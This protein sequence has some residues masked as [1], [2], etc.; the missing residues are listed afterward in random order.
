MFIVF[1]L[2]VTTST[3]KPNLS[4]GPPVSTGTNAAQPASARAKVPS[5][6]AS[7]FES[8]L[9]SLSLEEVHGLAV[10][11]TIFF[12]VRLDRQTPQEPWGFE[13]EK[14]DAR[15]WT[16]SKIAPGSAADRAVSPAAYFKS[17]INHEVLA[18]DSTT[19]KSAQETSTPLKLE[20]GDLILGLN[21]TVAYQAFPDEM[22]R[23]QNQQSLK[24]AIVRTVYWAKSDSVPNGVVDEKA[25]ACFA[26]ILSHLETR[27]L[28][29]GG[30]V[31]ALTSRVPE[32]SE[33]RASTNFILNQHDSGALE[34]FRIPDDSGDATKVR[35]RLGMEVVK[36]SVHFD[37]R[38]SL[39]VKTIDEGGIMYRFCNIRNG[40]YIDAINGTS[41]NLVEA[42]RQFS[43]TMKPGTQ[44]EVRRAET[45]GIT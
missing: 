7:P 13:V 28:E 14:G 11:H 45:P 43:C 44:F 4:A 17:K 6:P 20:I 9:S 8:W 36:A 22:K 39:Y 19:A 1:N 18:E 27:L 41:T 32:R 21:T 33:T 2:L 29:S 24:M 35:Y 15:S 26:A 42:L 23:A 31:V 37:G 38:E 40:D 5:K 16:I 10:K 3:E 30:K 25:C 34:S 12:E